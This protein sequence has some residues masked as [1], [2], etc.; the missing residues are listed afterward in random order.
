M[1]H[2]TAEN[3]TAAITNASWRTQLD[4]LGFVVLPD[5]CSSRQLEELRRRVDELYHEEAG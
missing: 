4:E 5:W 2:S 1:P 3:S